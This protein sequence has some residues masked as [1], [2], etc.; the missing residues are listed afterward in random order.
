MFFAAIATDIFWLARF[1]GRP[2]PQTIPVEPSVYKAFA[3][4]D[5]VLSILL[6]VGAYGLIFQKKFGFII[7]WIAMGMWIFDAL[8]VLNLMNFKSITFIGPSLVF[9]AFSITYLWRKSS[10]AQ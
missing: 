10:P 1:V 7:S 5:L 9:I 3:A 4:P 6:Y 8:L 2:F